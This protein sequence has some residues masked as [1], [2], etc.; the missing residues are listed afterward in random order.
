MSNP[1]PSFGTLSLSVG[2]SPR[3]TGEIV[4][5]NEKKKCGAIM[6]DNGGGSFFIHISDV[7]RNGHLLVVP[8]NSDTVE[9]EKGPFLESKRI[10]KAMS[11]NIITKSPRN[12]L[13]NGVVCQP[14]TYRKNRVHLGFLPKAFAPSEEKVIEAITAERSP[15]RSRLQ[16]HKNA[17]I[18][19][20]ED[21]K[22]FCFRLEFT[23]STKTD[24]K[25]CWDVKDMF[26]PLQFEGWLD[27]ISGAKGWRWGNK[28]SWGSRQD[29]IDALNKLQDVYKTLT[30]K[31]PELRYR[32]GKK[33]MWNKAP[34]DLADAVHDVRI[35]LEVLYYFNDEMSPSGKSPG[36]LSERGTGLMSPSSRWKTIMKSVKKLMRSSKCGPD[37]PVQ[38]AAHAPLNRYPIVVVTRPTQEELVWG[39]VN[40]L[41]NLLYGYEV[42]LDD[43]GMSPNHF[44]GV[45]TAWL[46]SPQRRKSD[47]TTSA[48]QMKGFETESALEALLNSN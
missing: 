39:L 2:S 26:R 24:E 8:K 5:W 27:W 4:R 10:F 9:F 16:Y 11:V 40:I 22:F 15:L 12:A 43:N 7:R 17:N 46:K 41:K 21:D 19:V 1:I 36:I 30:S 3:L 14:D 29:I 13:L 31:V 23:S 34:S 38:W 42:K 35:V 32:Q 18:Y 45:G 20:T 37:V 48:K 6:C 44:L 28:K 25:L 47:W 33:E